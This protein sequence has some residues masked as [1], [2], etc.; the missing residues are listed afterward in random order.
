MGYWW[1]CLTS[2]LGRLNRIQLKMDSSSSVVTLCFIV[3][4][5]VF[6]RAIFQTLFLRRHI[7]LCC[8]CHGLA[9][10]SQGPVLWFLPWGWH[11]LHTRFFPTI[12]TSNTIG[13]AWPYDWSGRA[14]CSVVRVCYSFPSCSTPLP[15]KLVASVSGLE[16]DS[17]VECDASRFQ[18]RSNWFYAAFFMIKDRRYIDSPFTLEVILLTFGPLKTSTKNNFLESL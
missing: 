16:Q 10:G 2:W 17:S 14:V 5:S 7:I 18:K 15:Q 13:S 4:R 11:K 6:T 3:K 9:P 1:A 12:D 8:R